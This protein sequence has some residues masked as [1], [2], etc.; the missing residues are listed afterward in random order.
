[1]Y[2]NGDRTMIILPR[3]TL[4]IIDANTNRIGEGLRLLEEYARMVL[5]DTGITQQLKNLRHTAV[6]LPV[7][8]QT[9]LLAARDSAGDVGRSM[10]V[11]G[12][13]KRRGIPEMVIAN[14]KRVQESL[15][16]MEELAKTAGSELDPEKYRKARFSLY[17]VEKELM[18]KLRRYDKLEKLRG[19]YVI[20]DAAFLRGRDPAG[21]A[22]EIIQSGV[23]VLQYRDKINSPGDR[24][25]NAG[26]IKAACAGTGTIFIINDSLETALAVDA[27]G[28]HIGQDDIPCDVARRLL[29]ADKVLGVSVRTAAEALKAR[30]QGADHLGVGAIYATSTKDDASVVGPARITEIRQAVDM[31]VVAI[32]GIS[33]ENIGDVMKAGADSAAVISAVLGAD[34][35]GL[36]V[37][38]LR[39]KIEQANG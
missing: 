33:V 13:E 14:A 15:R 34:D 24:L 26:K 27:G 28:L 25:I 31:P 18:L 4:R 6:S 7:E 32:G 20:I 5:N 16:V 3:E 11:P 21:L 12:E 17:T 36:A 10:N 2:H 23:T 35:A 1:M 30:D 9:G 22:L 29:P 8:I 38:L 19:L 37:R 39:E